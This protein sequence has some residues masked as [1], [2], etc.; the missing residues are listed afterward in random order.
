[1]LAGHR[2][3]AGLAAVRTRQ[4]PVRQR[5]LTSSCRTPMPRKHNSEA[6]I[7]AVLDTRA[8]AAVSIAYCLNGKRVVECLAAVSL[9]ACVSESRNL[10]IGVVAREDRAACPAEVDA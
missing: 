1:R 4:R 2:V 3:G 9:G 6:A 7:R 8:S 5:E 10:R